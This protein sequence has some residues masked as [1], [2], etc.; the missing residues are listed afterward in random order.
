MCAVNN[1]ICG[2]FME[3]NDRFL[4]Q[5]LS[6]EYRLEPMQSGM[7]FRTYDRVHTEKSSYVV[8]NVPVGQLLE[9]GQTAVSGVIRPFLKVHKYLQGLNI[10]V[11]QVLQVD[12]SLGK[13]LLEDLGEDTFYD[14]YTQHPIS[15]TEY[16]K[17]VDHLVALYKAQPLEGVEHYN[18]QLATI[19]GDFF[20]EDY[21]PAVTGVESTDPQ[22]EHLHSIL[23]EIYEVVACV[24]WG[25]ILWDY[26]SP[27]LMPHD[28]QV[29]VLDFQDAKHG[30][31]SYDL[32][33]LLYDARFPFAKTQRDFLFN[34]FVKCTDVEDIQAFRDSF[35]MAGLLRNLGVLG[36][37]ARSYYRDGRAEFLPKIAVL[38]PYMEEALQNPCASKLK[39]FLDLHMPENKLLAVS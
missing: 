20:L 37:F 26:H 28:G 9:D 38:W 17:A 36:R 1:A 30:P 16:E 39:Q 15:L 21:L 22:K 23:K 33:S 31:L 34:Y 32:A 4:T 27:N 3:L 6:G 11:P 12:E 10:P 19:R 2:V 5:F 35:E 29:A 8:M 25:T 7:S 14:I 18:T 24:K 13:I